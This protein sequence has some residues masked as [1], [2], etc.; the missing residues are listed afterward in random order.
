[1]RRRIVTLSAAALLALGGVVWAHYPM[2]LTERAM[3]GPGEEVVIELTNGHPF[4]N[5]RYEIE[6]PER[7]GVFPPERR[8]VNLAEK[9]EEV[10]ASEDAPRR[11]RL[12]FTPNKPGDYVFSIHGGLF[13]EPPQRKVMDYS[14]LVLHVKHETGAQ[15]GWRRVVG[16]PLEIVPLTRPY[17]IPV[18]SVFRGKV[19]S[20]GQPQP[21]VVVEAETYAPGKL[22]HEGGYLPN[23]RLGVLTDDAGVFAVTLPKAGWWLIAAA[24]D[25]GP[26]EQGA[27]QVV[28]RRAALWVYVGDTEFDRSTVAPE[29]D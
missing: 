14:K 15:V 20:D 17:A 2:L 16:D 23:Y 26:G 24:T 11:W 10:P 21:E 28:A 8:F 3:V 1:M 12:R 29:G 19:L 27:S 13:F 9:L 18:G 22:R 7:V 6:R 25:G 5:D 4:W